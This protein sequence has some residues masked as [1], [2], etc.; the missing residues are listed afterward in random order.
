M[1]NI[2]TVTK[3]LL[4][5]NVLMYLAT[6]VAEQRGVNLSAYLGLHLVTSENFNLAQLVT[7]MFMHAGFSHLF[8]NMFAVW[9]FGRI[10]EQVWGPKKFL[11]YY[12]VCG[13]GAGVIQQ[14][15]TGIHC[16]FALQDVPA[17]LVQ[18]LQTEGAEAMRQ[19]KNYVDATLGGYNA[20]LNAPTV[21]ASGAVYAILLGFGMIFPNQEMFVFP[22]PMPIKAKYFVMGYAAI[23]LWSGLANNPADNVAHFAH[24]GG[25]IFGLLL[26]LYWRKKNR[27]NGYYTY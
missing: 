8:F 12:L 23:E 20:M 19:G 13:V 16:Y 10:L 22:L 17:D 2:P 18:L 15:V 4:I 1:N 27:Q 6:V 21:G 25:M 26:I 7:Y 5:I 11:V 9:M 24:L 14:V 3:N